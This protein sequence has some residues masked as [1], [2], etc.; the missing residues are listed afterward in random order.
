MHKGR[1]LTLKNGQQ[2]NES[3]KSW[4][5][6]NIS[7]YA[8]TLYKSKGGGQGAQAKVGPC[9]AQSN[10]RR[11]EGRQNRGRKKGDLCVYGM[12]RME[13]SC[14][15]KRMRPGEEAVA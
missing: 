1:A 3:W 8:L 12:G 4:G 10:S 7:L 15:T 2:V 11:M 13:G 5:L 9:A 6:C 14:S